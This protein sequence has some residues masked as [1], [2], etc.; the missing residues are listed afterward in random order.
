[1]NQKK[2]SWESIFELHLFFILPS[3]LIL[4][5][6]KTKQTNK[7]IM[8]LR[9]NI[10][11]SDDEKN[12]NFT[13]TQR[14]RIDKD[15]GDDLIDVTRLDLIRKYGIKKNGK[16]KKKKDNRAKAYK[17]RKR[18]ETLA[19]DLENNHENDVFLIIVSKRGKVH[20][21]ISK[22]YRDYYQPDP[23]MLYDRTRTLSVLN[24]KKS[25]GQTGI[26][27]DYTNKLAQLIQK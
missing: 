4:S 13:Y 3:S 19:S 1:L 5:K 17:V 10:V 9:M 8:E 7:H 24:A 25:R 14:Q 23:Q 6:K 15:C 26:G 2:K 27:K 22:R 20:G 12:S 21:H 11:F 18:M 16:R